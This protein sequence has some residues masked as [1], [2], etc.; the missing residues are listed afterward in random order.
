MKEPYY[1]Y[2]TN[3]VDA[4]DYHVVAKAPGATSVGASWVNPPIGSFSV[5]GQ[6]D[7]VYVGKWKVVPGQVVPPGDSTSFGMSFPGADGAEVQDAFWTGEGNA[8]LEDDRDSIPGFHKTNDNSTTYSLI[9][10]MS[11]PMTISGL[12]FLLNQPAALPLSGMGYGLVPGPWTAPLPDF[13]IPASSSWSQYLPTAAVGMWHLAELQVP[14]SNSP[15][16]ISI[17][18]QFD[19]VPEPLSLALLGAGTL[20]LRRRRRC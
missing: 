4:T 9:N 19:V 15:N 3:P 6:P 14:Q 16:P 10:S 1:V 12:R 7:D 11:S 20:A 5:Q 13:V 18:H 2:S 8:R 17:M